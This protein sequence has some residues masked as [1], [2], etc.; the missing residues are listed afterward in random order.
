MLEM[1]AHCNVP[2]VCFINKEK[3]YFGLSDYFHAIQ[4]KLQYST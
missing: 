2:I 4:S 1:P 3:A